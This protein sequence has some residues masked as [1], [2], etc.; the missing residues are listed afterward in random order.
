VD[1]T[2][3]FHPHE[4]HAVHPGNKQGSKQA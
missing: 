1:I 3:E 4:L 2:D